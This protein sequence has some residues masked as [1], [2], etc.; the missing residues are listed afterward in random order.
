MLSHHRTEAVE[1]LD[2]AGVLVRWVVLGEVVAERA[3]RE[4]AGQRVDDRV[5]DDVAV[6]V[7]VEAAREVGELDAGQDGRVPGVEA[8]DVVAPADSDLVA[9]GMNRRLPPDLVSVTVAPRR[10]VASPPDVDVAF[11]R[12][13]PNVPEA[14]AETQRVRYGE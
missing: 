4:R 5:R 11:M 10:R 8:V 1:E 12:D 6:R 3:D 2:A 9:S 14:E 7:R 13:V